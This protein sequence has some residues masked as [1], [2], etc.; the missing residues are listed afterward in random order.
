[1]LLFEPLTHFTISSNSFSTTLKYML[2][3]CRRDLTLCLNVNHD[4]ELSILI[5]FSV[6]NS[7][8]LHVSK[9]K[10]KTY[11]KM[12]LPICLIWNEIQKFWTQEKLGYLLRV[13]SPFENKVW[14]HDWQLE[15]CSKLGRQPHGTQHQNTKVY[16]LL[17]NER[18]TNNFSIF[19]SSNNEMKPQSI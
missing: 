12:K 17:F 4:T 14:H 10:I 8:C 19:I 5:L 18:K 2:H 7:L 1:M 16:W 6:M 13:D 15:F 11:V 3:A 9:L